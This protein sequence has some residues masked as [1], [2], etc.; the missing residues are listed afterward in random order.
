MH[1]NISPQLAARL[2]AV[3]RSMHIVWF[4]LMMSVVTYAFAVFMIT[5]QP[6]EGDTAPVLPPFV[7]PIAAVAL[8][9][10]GV[11]LY[12]QM[13]SPDRLRAALQEKSSERDPTF[14]EAELRLIRVPPLVFTA[15]IIRWALF[16]SVAILGLVLA[17]L[18][19]SFEDFVPYGATAIALMAMAPPKGRQVTLSAIPLLP[20]DARS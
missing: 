19:R 6:A 18:N 11:M 14:T 7:F 1:P 12:R 2:D 10:T 16:E 15:S 17:I 5:R 9:V 20:S 8:A 4:A 3:S 13:T